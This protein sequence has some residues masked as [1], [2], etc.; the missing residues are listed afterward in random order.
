MRGL[1]GG[2]SEIPSTEW[3]VDFTLEHALPRA[4]LQTSYRLHDQTVG[5]VFTHFALRLYVYIGEVG[6]ETEAP[7][8]SRFVAPVKLEFEAFP[9]VMRKIIELI[10]ND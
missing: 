4:P 5:H 1:L 7:Q 6:G 8:G 9:S 2:M 3:T 10:E